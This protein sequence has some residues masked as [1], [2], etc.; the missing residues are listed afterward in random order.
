MHFIL[1]KIK[2][3]LRIPIHIIK[4]ISAL[5]I[6]QKYAFCV[7]RKKISEKFS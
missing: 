3:Y 2:S 1:L 5:V 4:Q 7:E 6:L